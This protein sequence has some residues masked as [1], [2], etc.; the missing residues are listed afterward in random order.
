MNIE[1]FLTKESLLAQIQNDVYEPSLELS[2]KLDEYW[3]LMQHDPLEQLETLFSDTFSRK[4][5]RTGIIL[6]VRNTM[7]WITTI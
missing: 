3:K 6:E 5:I 1:Y 2:F 4:N 7:H